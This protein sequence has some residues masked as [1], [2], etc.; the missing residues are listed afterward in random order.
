VDVDRDHVEQ[1]GLAEPL[2]LKASSRNKSNEAGGS[3]KRK[4]LVGY[5]KF[6]LLVFICHTRPLPITNATYSE[7]ISSR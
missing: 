1:N 2:L 5:A 7:A 6:G 4:M 3:G